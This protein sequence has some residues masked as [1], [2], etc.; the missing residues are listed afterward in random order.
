MFELSVAF[1]YLIPKLRQISVSIISLISVFVIAL[2]VWLVVVF[3]SV[4]HGLERMWI[5]KIIALTAPVRISPTEH[6][7]DSYYYRVDAISAESD[8]LEKSIGEKLASKTSDPY[9]SDSD[10]ETPEHWPTPEYDAKGQLIDPVKKAFQIVENFD[11]SSPLRA[12]EYA[13]AGA[14]IQINLSASKGKRLSQSVYVSCYD[15]WNENLARALI[16]DIILADNTLPS[17][18]KG[19]DAI[20]LPKNYKEAGAKIGDRGEIAFQAATAT[21]IQEQ[22]IPVY[23][24][25]FYD[26]GIVP[27]G[28]RMVIANDYVVSMVR[29][30]YSHDRNPMNNGINVSFSNLDQAE[31]V[32][33]KLQQAFEEQGI[34]SYWKIETF[35]EFEFTRDF[36]QQLQSEKNLFSLL[37]MIVIIVACSNIISM[38]IILVKDKRSEIGVLRSMGA[39][40]KSIAL[41]FGFCGVTMGLTGSLVGIIAALLTLHNLEAILD[42]LAWAQGFDVF[43]ANFYG[44]T[45]PNAISFEALTSVMIATA[46]ISLIAGIIPAIKASRMNPAAILRSE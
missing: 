46:I 36:L 6:Y 9:D 41:V 18:L 24:L 23:I 8:Y 11:A 26:P 40:S 45:L 39:S 7:Y 37:A 1:K 32:K 34:A 2:V 20:L 4:T 30:S 29:S 25:G 13:L 21:A 42:L 43:N 17:D 10:Q 31:N 28:G 27:M 16:D 3:F 38:L 35:R 33:Q 22:R 44:E 19:G 5:Q 15:P 12:S 14:K